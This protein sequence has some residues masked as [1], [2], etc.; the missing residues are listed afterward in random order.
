MAPP[1][2]L[3]A[4]LSSVF[5]VAQGIWT[6]EAGQ[7]NATASTNSSQT[8]DF[9]LIPIGLPLPFPIP[10]PD[11][12]KKSTPA[13]APAPTPSPPQGPVRRPWSC[14]NIKDRFSCRHAKLL[15]GFD[16]IKF[17]GHYCIPAKGA[18]CSDLEMPTDCNHAWRWGMPCIGWTG[19]QCIR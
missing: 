2:R 9:I 4:S 15:W 11:M 7:G 8:P 1:C 16:C 17:N 6:E 14:E 3:L 13:P 12:S 18:K 10:L 19:V 5:V